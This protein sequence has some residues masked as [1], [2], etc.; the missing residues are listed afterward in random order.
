MDS[1]P[2]VARRPGMTM[3]TPTIHA[4]AVLVGTKAVLILGPSGSGKSRLA[5]N[6]MAEGDGGALRFARLVA[7][8]RAILE[9]RSGRLIVR[10]AQPL[11]G[12]IEVRGLGLR[13]V[14]C[15][16]VAAVGCV[17]ELAAAGAARLPAPEAC[18]TTI[19]GV[20]MPR[21]PVA[22]GTNPLPLVLAWLMTKS[23][24]SE[25]LGGD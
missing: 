8:D 17:V 12:L 1:G 6:L 16:P 23:F 24:E 14:P 21:L 25:T 20:Q 3:M 15:E 9:T 19:S 11:T 2:G 7:D 4:S 10:P 5:W 18:V 13:R 22:P